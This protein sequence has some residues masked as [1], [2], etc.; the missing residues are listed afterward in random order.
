[1]IKDYG[2]TRFITGLRAFAA[3]AVVLLHAGGAGLK[4]LGPAGA[5]WVEMAG[6]GGVYV[7]FVISGFSVS[8]SY[9]AAP[10]Y[11]DYLARRF[12][13]IA[14]LYYAWIAIVAAGLVPPSGWAAVFHAPA[15]LYNVLMHVS[16]L[17][18][19]DYRIA[20]SLIEAEW[21]LPIEMA[22]YLVLPLVLVWARTL[23]RVALVVAT[24][25]AI[26]RLGLSHLNWLPVPRDYAG[27]AFIWSPIPYAFCFA[28]GL[29]AFRLREVLKAPGWAGDGALLGGLAAMVGV[30]FIPGVQVGALKAEFLAFSLAAFAM[31]ALG[32]RRAPLMNALLGNP[33]S[34][35]LGL[36]SFSIY[37]GHPAVLG[38]L[39]GAGLLPAA[40]LPKAVL[41]IAATVALASA[42]FFL[43]EQ[44]GQRMGRRL[45]P[46]RVR[47][48]PAE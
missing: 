27:L 20:N 13:R 40:P 42:T 43:V 23:L 45:L 17:S 15:D 22:Y 26:Y 33:V 14:P 11:G 37:L 16:F 19:L 31:V 34:Q 44:P 38:V 12:W 4:E 6:R 18:F 46:R 9:L 25:F 3:L 21:S 5:T 2:E 8:A 30:A 28:L 41:V 35:Y 1:M 7:F 39:G 48:Q 29:A 36:I 10:S 32:S 47:V 24:G